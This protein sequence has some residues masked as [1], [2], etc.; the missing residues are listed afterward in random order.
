[1]GQGLGLLTLLIGFTMFAQGNQC[2]VLGLLFWGFCWG[3]AECHHASFRCRSK[4]W[5]Y[6]A[7]YA[8][9]CRIGEAANPGP[10]EDP[11][12]VLGAFNPAGLPG[13]APFIVS[14]LA[15]GDIWAVSETHLSED[16]LQQFRA[17]LH[18]ARSPYKYVVG[19]H[20]VPAQ[21]DR[22]HHAAWRGVAL[23]SKFPTR[24]VPSNLPIDV[25]ESSRAVITTTLVHDTWITGGVVYGEPESS[26]YPHQKINNERL[27][28]EVSNQVCYLNKG[29]RFLAGDWNALQNDLPVFDQ[30]DGAGFVDLQDL[31]ARAWGSPIQPTCKQVTRK[32]FCYVSPEL[33]HLLKSVEIQQD[34]FPEHAV[35]F[36]VFHS[37]RQLIPRQVWFSPNP[38]PWPADWQVQETFWASTSGSCDDRYAALW[39]HIE[40]NACLQ[41][42]FQV[43]AN[44][45]GRAKTRQTRPVLD[46][47]VPP[48]RKGRNGDIQPHYVCASFRHAQWLRQ[49]RRIQAYCRHAKAHAIPSAHACAVW[50]SVVRAKGFHPSFERWWAQTSART[51]GAPAVMPMLPP[52]VGVAQHILDTMCLALRQMETDLQRASRQYARLKRESNPNAIFNDLKTHV[53]KGVHALLRPQKAIV[54][55]VR[56]DDSSVV[57]D[58]IFQFDLSQPLVCNGFQLQV[59]H[60]EHDC[61]WLQDLTGIEIGHTITQLS[62]LGTDDELFTTLLQ[63]WKEM[64]ERHSNVPVQRWDNILEFARAHL[65]KLSFSW[66]ELSVYSLGQCITHKKA[67]TA[68][69]LDGVSIHDLKAM[70]T[71]AFKNFVDIFAF[72]EQTGSWPTQ[73]VSG[74]VA[75]I[76]KVP[77]PQKALDFRPITVLGLLYSCWG[78]YH[79]RYAITKLDDHLP[80]GLFGSRPHRFAGQVWSQLLWTIEQAY[81]H[82]IQLCGIIADIQK[83]FNFLPRL[84]VLECCAIVGVSFA[85]LR[86]WAGALNTMPRRFQVNGSLSPPAYSNCGLPEGCALSCV[87]MMVVDMV[88][89][90]WMTKLFPL[91]QALSYVDDWQI[92]LTN[93]ASTLPAL[94]C[95]ERF[96]HAMDLWL[97]QRKTHTW[98]ICTQG[99]KT[100]R[101]QGLGSLAGGRNLGAHVQFTRQHTNSTLVARIQSGQAL[102]PKLRLSAC[103]YPTK[104]RAIRVAA[105]PRCLH[106]VPAATI[107]LQAFAQLR[108]GAMKGLRADAAGANP[109]VHLGLI[110]HPSTDPHCWAILQ[111]LRLTRDCGDRTRVE[112]VMCAIVGGSDKFPQNSITHTLCSRLQ[113]LGWNVQADG[114]ILDMW[115][116]FSLFDISMAELQYRVEMQ[117][118]HVVAAQTEHRRCF[119]GLDRC[120]AADTRKWLGSLEVSDQG[121]FRKI[122]NGSHFTQDGKMHCQEVDTDVCEFCACSDSRYHRFWECERFETHRTH[123]TTS[124]RKCISELPEV[125]TCAGWSLQPTTLHD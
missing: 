47:K 14:H 100:L 20:P 120:D 63:A 82:D 46:G 85:V 19:G 8:L 35:V 78:T 1:M 18:F 42:P 97:D 28:H 87:G 54:T 3:M 117:W 34:V 109:M 95:L 122:L 53:D 25:K 103:L 11:D 10:N 45:K 26:N 57:L 38:F 80:T 68:G 49:T 101:D 90:A 110:E 6:V 50:G 73:I 104:V 72:A 94:Q 105:W 107:S 5:T 88:F 91:C 84:V 64:W 70:P 81:E 51:P 24:E 67:T 16:S 98:S 31:A 43:P 112:D 21:N 32:D 69:G 30:L 124:E 58:R 17:G 52:P 102:W 62:K 4:L 55:E 59:I 39:K 29:P 48:P 27:L 40:D 114:A 125:L 92:L 108:S 79:A 61:L 106:G 13:K 37:F 83:A 41:M 66:P 23:M 116:S 111:T 113:F 89:H 115:G 93:P 76:A 119:T 75:C 15:Q 44:A 86:A 77:E 22:A 7:T 121:L 74:R 118:P 2:L 65:P 36:G 71:A 96:T 56:A 9:C 12:F 33:Q 99:R 60:A 123:L